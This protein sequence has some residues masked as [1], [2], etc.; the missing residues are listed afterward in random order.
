MGTDLGTAEW[1]SHWA[2]NQET[3]VL[4][5]DLA[6]NELYFHVTLER[7]LTIPCFSPQF[8]HLYDIEAELLDVFFPI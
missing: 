3:R 7:S 5:P 8:F 2:G 1:K 4:G 6:A